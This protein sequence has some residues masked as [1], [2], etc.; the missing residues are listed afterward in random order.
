MCWLLLRVRYG[1]RDSKC[2]AGT[3]N[4]FGLDRATV[5]FNDSVTDGQTETRAF[6]DRLCSEEW[7]EDL[8]Q[9]LCFDAAA[10]VADLDDSRF[11]FDSARD[12]Y[13]AVLLDRL[14]GVDQKIGPNLIELT[15]IT[16][17]E[18][19]LAVLAHESNATRPVIT[20][21]QANR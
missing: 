8:P 5:L 1:N 6:A 11:T 18:G 3:G 10:C 9:V 17:D 16:I 13:F 15:G 20:R 4:A 21:Q 14:R 2:G 19:Q 12:F 7:I